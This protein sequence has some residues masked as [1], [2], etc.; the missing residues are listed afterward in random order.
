MYLKKFTIL[1]IL[2]LLPT[3]ALHTYSQQRFPKPEFETGY[4]QPD[5]TTPQPR[6]LALEYIDI[7]M[8][9]V[10]LSLTSWF[11]IKKRSRRGILI[12]SVFSLLYFGFYRVGCVC[13]VGA[14]QNVA[15]SLFNDNYAVS[16]P[17][18]AFFL[19]PLIFALFFGRVFCASAC[20]LGAIQDLIVI[21]PVSL[22][23]WLQKA[24]GIFPYVYLSLAVLYAA[25]GTDFIICRYDPFVGIFRLGAEFH[26]I[27]LGISFLL[28]GLFV[29]RPYCRFICPYG[30]LLNIMS[31]FSKYHLS[32]SPSECIQCKLCTTSCP[33]DAINYPAGKKEKADSPQNIRRFILYLALIP[34]WIFTFGYILSESHIFLSKL[35]PDVY[36]ADL[37]VSKPKLNNNTENIDI[38]TFMSSGK[39]LDTLIEEAKEIQT[40]FYAGGWFA[41]GFIGLVIG[42]ILLNQVVFRKREDYQPDKGNCF[43]CGRCMGYCPVK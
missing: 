43:S 1:F 30:V 35:H 6:S 31:F 19:I 33:F 9:L 21:K 16:I 41:G 26:I 28:I 22:P 38:E 14:I 7:L 32:I 37:L 8:L 23:R 17:A 13:S 20:P 10:V 29:A 25:T 2:L 15:L 42:L 4:E 40:G 12:L 27:I 36:L 5:A 18:L 3:I 11:A 24:L 39:S 34:V